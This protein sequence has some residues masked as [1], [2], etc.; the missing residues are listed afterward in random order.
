MLCQAHWLTFEPRITLVMCKV[1]LQCVQVSAIPCYH[2]RESGIQQ[3][4][5][6]GIQNLQWFGIRNPLWYGIRNPEGWNPESKGLKSRIQMLGSRTFVVLLQWATCF[7][8]APAIR[9]IGQRYLSENKNGGDGNGLMWRICCI[10]SPYRNEAST[11]STGH[12]VQLYQEVIKS[13]RR[14]KNAQIWTH[15]DQEE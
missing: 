6:V 8:A 9:R 4:F 12:C 14:R 5:A 15:K 3:I 1:F 10:F 11:W 7:Q 13:V 2:V